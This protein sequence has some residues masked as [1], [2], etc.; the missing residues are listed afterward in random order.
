VDGDFQVAAWLVQ[1]S[2]NA[3]SRKGTTVHLEPK[4][5]SV[6]VCLAES[7]GQAVSK[8]K[9]LQTVWPDT[10]V[11]EGVLVRSIVELR[12]VF[13]D[14]AKEPRVIQTIAKRGYRLVAPV[15]PVTT[16]SDAAAVV[17]HTVT[18][19]PR[20]APTLVN[21]SRAKRPALALST[22]ALLLAGFLGN[23]GGV[24]TRV[25]GAA[26]PAILSL[27]VLPMQNLSGDPRQEYFA[28][29]MTEE[30]ITELSR[31]SALNVISRTSVMQ[32]KDSKKSLPDIA[33]ELHAD[34]IVEGSIVRLGDRVR[35][36]AQ[37]IRAANDTNVW[38]QTYDRD[39]QDVLVLQST[40][41]QAIAE[42]IR[43]QVKPQEAAQL[44]TV[45]PLNHKA[46][47]AYLAGRDHMDRAPE[48]KN[49][50]E[51]EYLRETDLAV[52]SFK[53]AIHE[54][55]T[56][57]PAYRAMWETIDLG[58]V[59]PRMDLVPAVREDIKKGLDLDDSL[60]ELHLIMARLYLQMDYNYPSAERE[61]QHVLELSPNAAGVHSAYG[62]Y[63]ER[64]GRN[65]EAQREHKLAHE[66]DPVSYSNRAIVVR[67]DRTLE[68]K[69]ASLDAGNNDDA[70]YRG[71]LGLDFQRRGRFKDAVEQYIKC[72]E[73]LGYK[74][75]AELLRRGYAQG[76]YKG[77]IRD[78]MEE[79]EKRSRRVYVPSFLPAFL[80]AGLGD[81][82][83][84]FRWMEKAYQEHSWCMLDLN[85][86][87]IWDPIRSDPQFA[88]YVRKA[89]LP[90]DSGQFV[91][92]RESAL[93]KLE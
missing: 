11:G 16:G 41:A 20:V 64:V 91:K 34:A 85:I 37:L 92:Q 14:D 31:V 30:L 71:W 87:P 45:R 78:W 2:L 66:L 90:E 67:E 7:A 22:A 15:V 83:D 60:V 63:L 48:F 19:G 9:L 72:M 54:D 28:D 46:F 25:F 39:L 1:P 18:P 35:V 49:G 93:A 52:A 8:E 61:Y 58:G 47:E 27:A 77:G 70:Y 43:V 86:D 74:R 62:D 75:E 4:V 42:E 24:R 82:E 5:M 51:Q 12:R 56:Y 53:Q 13:A 40:V 88:E 59:V 21:V 50:K 6:L 33:R 80:Y 84:A 10:F 73:M 26:S 65:D 38:A 23:V 81:R 44:K 55:P 79:W 3:V 29:A 32:Y 36:T 57:L 76:D 68:E 17:P 89:G 69:R